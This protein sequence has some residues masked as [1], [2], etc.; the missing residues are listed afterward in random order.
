MPYTFARINLSETDY[1]EISNYK[2]LENPDPKELNDIY[3]KYCRYKK[4]QSFMPIFDS[5]YEKNE[6]IGYYDGEKLVAFSM[7]IIYDDENVEALQFAWDYENPKLHL[8]IKSLRNECAIYKK[9][10]YK[11][12]YLGGADEY[13][14]KI[15]GFEI[16]GPV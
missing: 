3:I 13:K 14:K 11:H 5:E 10:G 6:I 8:G 16:M 2:F 15:D 12:F 1:S 7:I 4:F 9:R